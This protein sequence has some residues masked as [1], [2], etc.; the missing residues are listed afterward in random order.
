MKVRQVVGIVALSGTLLLAGCASRVTTA[1]RYS[2]FLQNYSDL[3][4]TTS[5]SGEPVLRWVEPNFQPSH[6][7]GLIY[8]PVRYY[9]QP[10]PTSQVNQQV[11]DGVLA[12]TNTKLKGAA[13]QRLPLVTT[14]G[15]GVLIFRG[16]ITAVDT[17]DRDL[18]PYEFI[19]VALV[20]AGTRAATGTR[21]KDTNFY[22]EGELLDSV[23]KKP[24][25]KVV[26]KGQGTEVDNA[27]Q[28]VTLQDLKS[29][30]DGMATDVLMFNAVKK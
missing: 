25:F 29:V 2:G 16:A 14:P 27:E 10:H 5:A 7:K 13:E 11:L 21:P 18:K 22:F 1:D 9:P 3:K 8:E 12:Y 20:I 30:I 23:T 6:Y 26:R 15:P 4:Q 28:Q 19:P 17:S 24:V